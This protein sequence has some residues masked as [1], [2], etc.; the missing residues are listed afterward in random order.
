MYYFY[1]T[2]SYRKALTLKE[3]CEQR[4]NELAILRREKRMKLLSERR[5]KLMNERRMELMNEQNQNTKI[6][7]LFDN[8]TNKVDQK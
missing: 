2:M 3:L 4:E 5:M 1:I 7:T 8:N 6:I